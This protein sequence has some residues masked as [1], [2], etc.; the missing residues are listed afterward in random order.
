M[1]G[2]G[3]GGGEGGGDGGGPSSTSSISLAILA[4]FSHSCG[5]KA[6]GYFLEKLH[7]FHKYQLTNTLTSTFGPTL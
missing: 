5:V 4:T 2:G 7:I 3:E 1:A 6:C